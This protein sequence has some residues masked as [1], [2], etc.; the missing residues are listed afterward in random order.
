M[1]NH[2]RHSHDSSIDVYKTFR[3]QEQSLAAGVC[4]VGTYEETKN[5]NLGDEVQQ[6]K[7]IGE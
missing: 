1:K 3:N 5:I 4:S 6:K 7:N 2:H